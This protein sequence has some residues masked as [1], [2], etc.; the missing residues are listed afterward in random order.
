[1]SPVR[2]LDEASRLEALHRYGVLDTP[3]EKQF[4]RVVRLA[5]RWFDVPIS[6]VTL[7]D[8]DRQWFKACVG[9]DRRETGREVSFCEHNIHDEEMLVVADASTD[10]RFE[11][12]PLVTGPPGIRFYAGAPLVTPEGQI[13]GSLCVID[14]EPRDP[15]AMD[16]DVLADLASIVVDELELRVANKQLTRKN[17]QIHQL[18]ESLT[19]AEETERERLSLLLQENLQQV[20]QAARMTVV[21]LAGLPGLSEKHVERIQGASALIEEAIDVTQGLSSRFAPPV[22]NQSLPDTFRWLAGKMHATYGLEVVLDTS[23]SIVIP[24]ETLKSVLYRAARELL[25]NVVKHAEVEQTRLSLTE[26]EG[27]LCLTVED[28]GVGFSSDQQFEEGHGL[29][30]V[31]DRIEALGGNVKVSSRPGEGTRVWVRVPVP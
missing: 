24:D 8:E 22:E 7:L 5:S 10:P 12:N 31:R 28:E 29:N 16:L 26:D 21:N 15:E 18:V 4:D 11:D 17:Q 27:T 20:L 30:G 13:L 2:S 25:F 9:V 23:D 6:L 14:T 3:R 1:M 19:T